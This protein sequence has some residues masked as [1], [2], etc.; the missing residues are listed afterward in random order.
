M[1]KAV[2]YR[3]VVEIDKAED[4]IGSIYLPEATKLLNEEFA[5]SGVVKEI[6]PLAFKMKES[7]DP[8]VSVGD[9]IFFKA[10]G[11]LFRYKDG[12]K[13]R[14]INDEDIICLADEHDVPG[15]LL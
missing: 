3:I 10:R 14:V 5:E 9:R 11:N 7:T 8:W 1:P 13:I 6:G 15:N 4:K 2:G 12:R